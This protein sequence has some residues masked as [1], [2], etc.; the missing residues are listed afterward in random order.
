MEENVAF[1]IKKGGKAS[2]KLYKIFINHELRGENFRKS[3][4][5]SE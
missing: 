5:K 1:V 2:R 4:A 3:V